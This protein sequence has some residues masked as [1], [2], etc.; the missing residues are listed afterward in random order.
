MK[1]LINYD[2]VVGLY[3]N[4][5]DELGKFSW[6]KKNVVFFKLLS[7]DENIYL[8]DVPSDLAPLSGTAKTENGDRSIL[9]TKGIN[10][11]KKDIISLQFNDS[12][13]LTGE[14]R[15]LVAKFRILLNNQNICGFNINYECEP[16]DLVGVSEPQWITKIVLS[17]RAIISGNFL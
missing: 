9:F 8:L 5:F 14:V 15:E 12:L 6:C 2:N 3:E 11:L 16:I 7:S 13:S 10:I 4:E 17:K 1:H